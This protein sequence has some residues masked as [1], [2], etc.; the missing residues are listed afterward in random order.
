[1]Y[2]FFYTNNPANNH[3][4]SWSAIPTRS[5]IARFQDKGR[6][7]QSSRSLD[8]VR[9]ER[10]ARS[11]EKRKGRGGS[12]VRRR[13]H[14]AR[15]SAGKFLYRRPLVGHWRGSDISCNSHGHISPPRL[16]RSFV[17][18]HSSLRP[19]LDDF[20]KLSKQRPVRAAY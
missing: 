2:E 5:Q 16:C 20:N 3:D 13:V 4:L 6:E 18:G 7:Y 14:A 9:D 11:I 10:R 15:F 8:A 17:V 12:R 19:S 1:M